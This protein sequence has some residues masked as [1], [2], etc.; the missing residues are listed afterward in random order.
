MAQMN[1]SN[2]R[3]DTA[4]AAATESAVIS[5]L[6]RRLGGFGVE[7]ADV[8]GNVETVSSHVAEQA[9]QFAELQQTA[10]D[11]V[12]AN[13]RIDQA[14]QAAKAVSASAGDDIAQSHRAVDNAVNNIASLIQAVGRIEERLSAVGGVLKQVAGVS[15]T[16]ETIAKQTNLLALNATIEAA[17]AGDAG[18]G[19]AV[20]AGEVKNLAEETRKATSHI[21]DTV[22]DLTSQIGNLIGESA[23]ATKNAAAAQQGAEMIQS[24]IGKVGKGFDNVGGEIGAIAAAASGNLD[25][26]KSVLAQLGGL[27]KGVQLSSTNLHQADQRIGGLLRLSE[28]LIAYIAGSGHQT[29]DTIFIAA[30]SKAAGEVAAIFEAA[31]QQGEISLADLFDENYREIHGSNPLQHVTAFVALTDRLLPAIQ[32]P[33]LQLDPRVAFCAAVDR[34]GYLPTHNRKFSKPQGADPVWNA[35]NCR[36][37]RIFNDRTGLAAG[38]NTK[39]FLLQTYRRDMGGGQFVLMQDLSVPI[40]VRGRH[41]GGL[42]LGYKQV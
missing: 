14:A 29:G 19:F 8:A 30:V 1:R 3:P 6:A 17:R 5:E 40:L 4:P 12:A 25:H 10:Q 11:M 34:N 13:Q 18:R 39:P 15:S 20:V 33:L 37:R 21:S 22:R 42:R 36:N 24:V 32:E 27:A 31:L 23:G 38:R 9:A 28:G 16:I 2:L 26:C 7:V 41:W 35:A